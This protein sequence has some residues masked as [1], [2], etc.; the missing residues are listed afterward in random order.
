M[1]S[2]F[3]TEVNLSHFPPQKGGKTGWWS[4]FLYRLVALSGSPSYNAENPMILFT[5]PPQSS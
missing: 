5:W 4:R 3:A 1:S 2:L